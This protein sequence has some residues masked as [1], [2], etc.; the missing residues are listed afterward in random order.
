V[1]LYA[2]LALLGSASAQV[3]SISGGPYGSA[4]GNVYYTWTG[5]NCD[6]H[7]LSTTQFLYPVITSSACEEARLLLNVLGYPVDGKPLGEYSTGSYLTGGT[8]QVWSRNSQY[9]L[10]DWNLR[11]EGAEIADDE[12][13]LGCFWFET[14]QSVLSTLPNI[15]MYHS[16]VLLPQRPVRGSTKFQQVCMTADNPPPPS[17]SAP[18]SPPPSPSTPLDTIPVEIKGFLSN[19]PS[20]GAALYNELAYNGYANQPQF[21]L[22]ASGSGSYQFT[23]YVSQDATSRYRLDYI[24]GAGVVYPMTLTTSSVNPVSDVAGS[25]DVKTLFSRRENAAQTVGSLWAYT[26]DT[27]F[28]IVTDPTDPTLGALQVA[29]GVEGKVNC[30]LY[31]DNSM[32]Y[33]SDETCDGTANNVATGT[34]NALRLFVL[35]PP[36]P[37]APPDPPPSL[38]PNPLPPPPINVLMTSVEDTLNLGNYASYYLFEGQKCTWPYVTIY[39]QS[40]CD[41][42]LANYGAVLLQGKPSQSLST[43][44]ANI[45]TALNTA[46]GLTLAYVYVF[47]CFYTVNEYNAQATV[48]VYFAELSGATAETTTP[49]VRHICAGPPPSPSAPPQA[50]PSVPPSPSAPPAPP[51]PP[52]P[53][54]DF[55]VSLDGLGCASPQMQAAG[56]NTEIVQTRGDC[57]D[58]VTWWNLEYRPLLSGTNIQGELLSTYDGSQ[59]DHDIA[60]AATSGTTWPGCYY[61]TYWPA[62]PDGQVGSRA[63]FQDYTPGD[64]LP[65]VLNG[66]TNICRLSR[67]PSPPPPSPPPPTPP[68]PSPPPPSPPPPR[69]RLCYSNQHPWPAPGPPARAR[70]RPPFALGWGWRRSTTLASHIC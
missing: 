37:P 27:L 50:S 30:L 17:P 60:L 66:F 69:Y 5:G 1:R 62:S 26:T 49:H 4:S 2:M 11:Y 16:S 56:V 24:D 9:D 44:G 40:E 29:Q 48:P 35:Y 10:D 46:T 53:P 55:V 38:P 7:S 18:P 63:Y 8:L 6:G 67:S 47:G 45:L 64:P 32:V 39:T 12:S 33:V 59:L 31:E 36:P 23:K 51:R 68:S 13:V 15:P 58:A 61:D 22:Q 54:Y 14:D 34:A 25:T 21:V 65:T 19:D 28:N 3:G 20:T 57:L 43:S 41:N 70:R 42:V 52:P